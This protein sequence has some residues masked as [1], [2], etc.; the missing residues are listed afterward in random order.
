MGPDAAGVD[1][2]GALGGAGSDLPTR[3]KYGRTLDAPARAAAE[4]AKPWSL[5]T[6]LSWL[7]PDERQWFWWDIL[8]RK[9]SGHVIVEVPVWPEP[10]AVHVMAAISSNERRPVKRGRAAHLRKTSL[11]LSSECGSAKTM[12]SW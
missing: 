6:W 11:T 9:G 12:N 1:R 3:L 2:P 8:A 10:L 7:E 4:A 5:R